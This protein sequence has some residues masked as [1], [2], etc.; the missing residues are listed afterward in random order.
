MTAI[1]HITTA[2]V[3]LA[4]ARIDEARKHFD[5][6]RKACV[7]NSHR[8]AIHA[9]REAICYDPSQRQ[10]AKELLAVVSSPAV[11]GPGIV[12]TAW[13]AWRLKRH[14]VKASA[15]GDWQRVLEQGTALLALRPRSIPAL[16]A[17]GQACVA[18]KCF[19]SALVYLRHAHKVR[20]K[21]VLV[22]R[23]CGRV[24]GKVGQFDEAVGCWELV[25]KRV[26][27]D[28]EALRAIGDLAVKKI[29]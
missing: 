3:T 21:H 5:D 25:R 23:H 16:L 26:P 2:K 1:E 14:L 10:Y 17:L 22:N 7:G 11:V 20:P 8:F 13:A 4:S 6:G 29:L 27:G 18:L 24:L 19:D 9:F 15:A 28:P 12:A